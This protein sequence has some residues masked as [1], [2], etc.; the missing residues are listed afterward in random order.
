MRRLDFYRVPRSRVRMYLVDVQANIL[1]HLATR[2]VI[3]MI[4]T[5]DAPDQ[6][7]ELNP[8]FDIDGI[9]HIL[10]TQQMAAVQRNG[11]GECA[12]SLAAYRDEI[13]WAL[14]ILL[15]DF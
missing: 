8:I 2:V 13:T 15:F 11:L 1:D 4:A 3:P 10:Q 6:A 9:L 12:G 7:S 5:K 14:D